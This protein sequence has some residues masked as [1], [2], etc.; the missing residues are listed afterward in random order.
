MH[1]TVSN[2]YSCAVGLADFA[3]RNYLPART[4]VSRGSSGG[5]PS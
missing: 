1:N 4:L 3:F 5:S 2:G